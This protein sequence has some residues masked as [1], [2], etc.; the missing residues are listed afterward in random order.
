MRRFAPN[1]ETISL[2]LG[3]GYIE[4][5]LLLSDRIDL[6]TSL[7]ARVVTT[8]LSLLHTDSTSPVAPLVCLAAIE[9]VE[10]TLSDHLFQ[11]SQTSHNQLS[12]LVDRYPEPA[13]VL[14]ALMDFVWESCP[15][16]N[17]NDLLDVG[18]SQ[19]PKQQSSSKGVVPFASAQS[20]LTLH[21]NFV[22][23]FNALSSRIPLR[24]F[25]GPSPNDP[26][27]N[28]PRSPLL[29]PLLQSV[30]PKLPDLSL[31]A[32]TTRHINIPDSL[33]EPYAPYIHSLPE[34]TVTA[35]EQVAQK[36]SV[37]SDSSP[38]NS[39][40]QPRLHHPPSSPTSPRMSHGSPRKPDT[41]RVIPKN[42][43]LLAE[44]AL[45]LLATLCAPRQE[46]P[47][48]QALCDLHDISKITS[49]SPEAY[50]FSRLYEAFGKWLSHPTGALL[51]YYL[52]TGNKR[53]R[54][55][56]L[57]RTDP[58]VLL[59]PLLASLKRR[60]V[61]GAVPAD[62]FIPAAIM[63]IMT[64]DKGFCEAIDTIT[65][66]PSWIGHIEDK[67][68]LGNEPIAISGLIL[69]VCS[70]VVQQ[71]LVARR[72]HPECMTASV[73]LAIMGN[74]S[75]DVTNLH[76]VA[77]ERLLSLV[78]FLSRR[79][80]KAIAYAKHTE[81]MP[82]EPPRVCESP[83]AEGFETNLG[84]A[85]H[86]DEGCVNGVVAAEARMVG[87]EKSDEFLERLSEYLGLALEIIVSVLRSRSTVA[88]NRHLVYA[89]L[90]RESI[91]ESDHVA[92]VSD[93]TGALT[94][95]IC[96]MLDFFGKYVDE[97]GDNNQKKQMKEGDRSENDS[98]A[99]RVSS[100]RS[101]G[102]S[103]ERVFEVIDEKGRML[104]G[105]LFEGLPELRFRYAEEEV[106]DRFLKA[107]AWSIA[108]RDLGEF[109][110]V[111][112][113]ALPIGLPAFRASE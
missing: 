37:K 73:C 22:D 62:V 40:K 55:F 82:M 4:S 5:S 69:L 43:T 102:I 8:S 75:A 112:G 13:A 46:N 84:K 44:R 32:P 65:L 80:K 98:G 81:E 42:P 2:T 12:N 18:C 41:P 99:R 48:R 3:A 74:V 86:E 14:R 11:H 71:S 66:Q 54:T 63:L 45:S 53:F 100:G 6:G 1:D 23:A 50:P 27:S 77:A 70:R 91:M 94:H 38:V 21:T 89:L 97:W 64:S 104:R 29:S 88:A 17:I 113:V 79:R 34:E 59:V 19:V 26:I 31:K 49:H 92:A 15:H 67:S 20:M 56:A 105:D 60:C 58:D 85:N 103:V 101:S 106:G 107:Y 72:H 30:S 9:L 36:I 111:E 108:T 52:I 61:V 83:R 28:S 10:V 95:M 47:Y 25:V 78:D 57:A 109:E 35:P 16:A 96:R 87:F 24:A 68:R 33:P 90:H 76:S 110:E 93:Q 39:G 7:I 51:V